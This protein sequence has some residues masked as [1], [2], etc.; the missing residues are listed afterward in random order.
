MRLLVLTLIMLSMI[1][2]W[3]GGRSSLLELLLF[4]R[5]FF[6]RLRSIEVLRLPAEAVVARVRDIVAGDWLLS[7][8][9]RLVGDLI[10]F[11]FGVADS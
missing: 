6:M 5:S 4:F 9:L 7:K 3:M 11:D 2:G 10:R 1:W 8:F